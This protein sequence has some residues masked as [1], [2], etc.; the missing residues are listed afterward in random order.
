METETNIERGMPAG[1]GQVAARKSFGNPGR[2]TEV[3]YDVR[4]GGWL[5]A[6]WQDLGY[7][8][9]RDEEPH[10]TLVA[11]VTLASGIVASTAIFMFFRILMAV[12][13]FAVKDLAGHRVDLRKTSPGEE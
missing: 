3:G 11:V 4:G 9:E 1:R 7:G 8:M 13:H 12:D 10:F 5:E 2:N 6:L